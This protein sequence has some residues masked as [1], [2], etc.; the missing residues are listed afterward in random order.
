MVT[1]TVVRRSGLIQEFE[2]RGHSFVHPPTYT[3]THTHIHTPDVFWG[4][5]LPW[6]IS[7]TMSAPIPW[8]LCNSHVITMVTVAMCSPLGNGRI[9]VWVGEVWTPCSLAHHDK[10]Q[11]IPTTSQSYSKD[12]ATFH[13]V[14]ISSLLVGHRLRASKLCWP[15]PRLVSLQL[16]T[17]CLW[18]CCSR[19][20]TARK[21]RRNVRRYQLGFFTIEL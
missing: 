11:T 14:Y 21:A 17:R 5:R 19:M 20:A 9:A 4:M 18:E 8:G 12:H 2:R 16:P 6:R 15:P 10:Q 7:E 1:L 13:F 3:H